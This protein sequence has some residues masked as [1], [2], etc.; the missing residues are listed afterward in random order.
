MDANTCCK[1]RAS[2]GRFLLSPLERSRRLVQHSFIAAHLAAVV[3]GHDSDIELNHQ[4][5]G[6]DS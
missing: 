6:V 2:L 4:E 3:E 1:A 5:L